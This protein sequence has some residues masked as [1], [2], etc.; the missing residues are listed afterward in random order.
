MMGRHDNEGQEQPRKRGKRQPR[1]TAEPLQPDTSDATPRRLPA[2]DDAAEWT[3]EWHLPDDDLNDP[4][5][6]W[7]PDRQDRHPEH[8]EAVPDRPLSPV[9]SGEATGQWAP[10]WSQQPVESGEAT[11]QWTPDWSQQPAEPG[12]ATGQWSQDWPSSAPE[13]G[14]AWVQGTPRSAAETGEPTGQWTSD[15]PQQSSELGETAGRRTSDPGRPFADPEATGQW[16]AE[17]APQDADDLP[18]NP[19]LPGRGAGRGAYEPS[20]AADGLPEAGGPGERTGQWATEGTLHPQDRLVY[21]GAAETSTFQ[22]AGFEQAG[23]Q[24]GEFE[25]PKP[26]RGG[27]RKK[28]N[29]FLD[30]GWNEDAP[31]K[32]KRTMILSMAA[33]VALLGGTVAG[34]QIMTRPTGVSAACPP[35]EDCAV[36]A[37]NPVAPDPATTAPADPE[38]TETESPEKPRTPK[39]TGATRAPTSPASSPPTRR[40]VPKRTPSASPTEKEQDAG[41]DDQP[42]PPPDVR[43][44][45]KEDEEEEKKRLD[46]PTP[47]PTTAPPTTTPPPT[48]GPQ[49]EP[50]DPGF[51]QQGLVDLDI[52]VG[53]DVLTNRLTRYEAEISVVNASAA[54][55]PGLTLSVPVGGVVRDVEGADW[56]Q[57][58]G[59]LVLRYAGDMPAGD[60]LTITFTALGNPEAPDTCEVSGGTCELT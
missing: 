43:I 11:G 49:P 17:P 59:T 39:A 18:W 57:Q 1:R 14:N 16:A 41:I 5:S 29:D 27:R 19:E 3:A 50:D 28:K 15:W 45:E 60:Q 56:E 52:R 55:L 13:L 21:S 4:S 48:S 24:P 23:T 30:S 20:A 44:E 53:F 33:A 10:D 58:G 32:S 31:K 6:P 37:P 26:S 51:E 36:V 54:A 35:S 34:V 42:T 7:T 47:G 8:G 22:Q 9:E 25:P 2:D 12:Q 38:A 40:V 46:A